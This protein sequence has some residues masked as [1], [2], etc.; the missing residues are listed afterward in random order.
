MNLLST[1]PELKRLNL[2]NPYHLIGTGL[3]SG[4][5]AKAPGTWGTLAS[6]PFVVLAEY[7]LTDWQF[8]ALTVIAFFVGVL[9]SYKVA[10]VT[11]VEDDGAIVWDEW[12]GLTVTVYF[13]PDTVMG[14]L[15][16]VLAFRFF[17]IL[18]PWPIGWCDRRLKGGWGVMIDD[19]LAGLMA[20]A[21]IVA[22]GHLLG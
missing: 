15:L 21:V 19:V 14:V 7:W 2:W 13:L 16:A 22:G 4:L 11:G 6:V 1:R 8:M 18:K 12:V 10:A 17:D 20:A 5:A 3:G 9:A